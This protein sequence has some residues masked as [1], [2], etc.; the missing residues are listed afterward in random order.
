MSGEFVSA[1]VKA[2]A[3]TFKNSKGEEITTALKDKALTEAES[4]KP[5]DKLWLTSWP[6]APGSTMPI[7]SSIRIEHSTKK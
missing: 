2:A 5:G 6:A 7:I 1:D 3:S 4:L